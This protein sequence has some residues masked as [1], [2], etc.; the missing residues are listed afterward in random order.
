MTL[1]VKGSD[2]TCLL[3]QGKAPLSAAFHRDLLENV[4]PSLLSAFPASSVSF[5]VVCRFMRELSTP[6]IYIEAARF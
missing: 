1:S 6:M 3:K 4:L 2:Y 5:S